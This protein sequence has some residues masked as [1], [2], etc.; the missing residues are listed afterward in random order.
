MNLRVFC[1]IHFICLGVNESLQKI[2][3]YFLPNLSV[4]KDVYIACVHGYLQIVSLVQILFILL[5]TIL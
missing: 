4:L 3:R 1:I 5:F 2:K